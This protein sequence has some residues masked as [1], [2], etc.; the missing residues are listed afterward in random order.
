MKTFLHLVVLVNLT[1][2]AIVKTFVVHTKYIPCDLSDPS[3]LFLAG[4]T[5]CVD[6]TRNMLLYKRN[7]K[8]L[9]EKFASAKK[10]SIL[11][12]WALQLLKACQN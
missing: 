3:K 4:Q 12:K 6:E 7:F 8:M 11:C 10:P 1:A 5:L 2:Y 9:I